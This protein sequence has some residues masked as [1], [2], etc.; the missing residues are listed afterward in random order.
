MHSGCEMPYIAQDRPVNKKKCNLGEEKKAVYTDKLL[1]ELELRK[2][3]ELKIVEVLSFNSHAG[4][5][6]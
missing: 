1:D 3:G 6:R 5:K 4:C 2:L